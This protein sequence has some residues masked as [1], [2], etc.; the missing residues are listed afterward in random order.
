MNS[1]WKLQGD[2]GVQTYKNI[3]TPS[4]QRCW[5]R[6]RQ[7]ADFNKEQKFLHKQQEIEASVLSHLPLSKHPS[8]LLFVLK[9][10]ILWI[11]FSFYQKQ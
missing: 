9:L 2:H 10:V 11:I 3:L 8:Q 1:S 4:R 7:T 5:R 6:L